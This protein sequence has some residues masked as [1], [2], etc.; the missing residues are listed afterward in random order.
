MQLKSIIFIILFISSGVLYYNFTDAKEEFSDVKITRIIDGDTVETFKGQRIRLKGIN[1]PEKGFL[2]SGEA[3]KFLEEKVLD[4]TLNIVSYGQD[5]YGRTLGFLILEGENINAKILEKGLASLYYYEKD[6]FYN[7]MEGAEKFA[8]INELGIYKK[9][10]NYGCLEIIE[11]EFKEPESLKLKN[12]CKM[13]LEILIK[14]D[15]T[16][17]YEESVK[18]SEILEKTFSHIWNDAGDTIYIWDDKGLLIF[19]RY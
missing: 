1:T 11:F 10:N 8:R 6:E 4:K 5:K 17:M 19:H 18:P 3:T 9:S 16:H 15:A 7:E 13:T 12:N 2:G 14:D